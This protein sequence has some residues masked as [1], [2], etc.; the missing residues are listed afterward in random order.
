VEQQVVKQVTESLSQGE[1]KV[2]I[3]LSP[4]SLGKV[5][6]EMTQ[7][8]DGTLHIALSAEN[9]H[10]KALLEQHTG[11]LQTLVGNQT[12]K[13][14]QVEVS[15]RQDSQHNLQDDGQNGQSGYQ[16]QERRQQK[17]NSEDFLQKLR[18]GLLPLDVE[19]VS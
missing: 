18:L 19:A 15:Q 11:N 12:Q 7:Q 6:V 3:Q 4:S 9:T 10:T 8:K 16:Q 17:Q 1:T 14:V 2:E 5:T 13:P